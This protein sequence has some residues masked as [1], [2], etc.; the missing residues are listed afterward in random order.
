MAHIEIPL[1]ILFSTEGLYRKISRALLNGALLACREINEDV[2]SDVHFSPVIFDP[3]GELSLYAVGAQTLFNQGVRHV[4]GCYTS[5]SRKEVI[6]LFEKTDALLW[7]PTHYEGFESSPNV[8]YN[9]AG[10]SHHLSPLIDFLYANVGR[11]AYCIGSNY[12][13]GWESTRVFREGILRRG[14]EVV[15]ERYYAL[16]DT[17]AGISIDDIFETKPDFIYNTLIGDSAYTFYRAFRQACQDRGIDQV[18]RFPIATCNLSEPELEEIGAGAAEGHISSSSYFS[19]IKC[20]E[21]MRFVRAYRRA[22]PDN[23]LTCSE[24]EAAYSAVHLLAKSA[25]AAASVDVAAI[26]KQVPQQR[27]DAPSGQMSIDPG[28]FFTPASGLVSDARA[29]IF[30]SIFWSKPLG[31]FA[32]ILI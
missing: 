11:K 19:S 21:N 16:Y 12:V 9:G 17:D 14:G 6:P 13:W 25:A 32:P 1:G 20:E 8:I 31:Q 15:G 27:F 30:N 7:Y 22:Y 2:R 26:K 28:T 4:I 3:K 18:A 23:P 24:A 5:S 10:P 29:R